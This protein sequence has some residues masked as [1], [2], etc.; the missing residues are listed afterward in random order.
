M[1]VPGPG[2]GRGEET[3]AGAA[4]DADEVGE[5][6]VLAAVCANV[7]W[8]AVLTVVATGAGAGAAWW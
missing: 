4:L 3:G 1:P 5:G 6:E 7:V 8:L 2:P